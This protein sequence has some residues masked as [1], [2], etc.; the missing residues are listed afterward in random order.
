MIKMSLKKVKRFA[1]AHYVRYNPGLLTS[2]PGSSV[3]WREVMI[4]VNDIV[5]PNL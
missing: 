5:A 3:V 4:P 1:R 2:Q